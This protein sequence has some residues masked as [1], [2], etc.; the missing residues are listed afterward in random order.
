MASIYKAPVVP[1]QYGGKWIAWNFERTRIVA[2]GATLGEAKRLAEAAGET[3]VILAKV[4]R[5]DVRFIGGK[6]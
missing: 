4:P 6:R 1:A 2:S 5:S 3:R